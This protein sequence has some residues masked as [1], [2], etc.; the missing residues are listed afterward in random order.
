V[1]PGGAI[2]APRPVPGRANHLGSDRIQNNVPC[3]LKQVRFTLYK[4]RLVAINVGGLSAILS[5]Q[6][7]KLR[8][9]RRVLVCDVFPQYR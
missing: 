6:A 4:D 1:A 9:S 8:R 7:G 5:R 2:A 3:Q